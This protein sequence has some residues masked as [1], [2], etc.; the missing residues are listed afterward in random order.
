MSY[1][2]P[3][4]TGELRSM[5]GAP[6]S[7]GLKWEHQT[8]RTSILY[9]I[10]LIKVGP[11]CTCRVEVMLMKGES[12]LFSGDRE[13]KWNVERKAEIM[14]ASQ[15]KNACWTGRAAVVAWGNVTGQDMFLLEISIVNLSYSLLY[16]LHKK[17]VHPRSKG[18]TWAFSYHMAF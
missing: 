17:L 14:L 7:L 9:L 8:L 1:Y 3:D 11:P 5:F 10:R 15:F 6:S 2:P 12:C 16:F 18:M 4:I 13:R